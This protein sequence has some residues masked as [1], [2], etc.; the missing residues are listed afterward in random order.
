[1]LHLFLLRHGKATKYQDDISDYSRTLNKQGT[2]QVNQ[3][4]YILR[5]KGIKVDHVLASSAA[6]TVETAEIVNHF[7]NCT[8]FNLRKFLFGRLRRYS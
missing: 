2:A 5:E 3:L 6:R 4:G 1:M 8:A 7:L